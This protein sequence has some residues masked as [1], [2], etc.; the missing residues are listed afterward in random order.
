MAQKVNVEP[1][2][3]T[4]WSNSMMYKFLITNLACHNYFSIRSNSTSHENMFKTAQKVNVEPD[5]ATYW[6]NTVMYKYLIT[7]YT[8]PN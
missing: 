1:Y 4:Y 2:M 3:A 7:N 8:Y 5:M 6:F